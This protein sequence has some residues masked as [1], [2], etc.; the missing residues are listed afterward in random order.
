M[1]KAFKALCKEPEVRIASA[2]VAR[3]CW[4]LQPRVY[5]T[6]DELEKRYRAF[7]HGRYFLEDDVESKYTFGGFVDPWRESGL[8][9]ITE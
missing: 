1:R 2:R 4:P 5:L 8:L 6:T 7:L 3:M 9:I